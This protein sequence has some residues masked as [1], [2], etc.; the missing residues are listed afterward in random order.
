MQKLFGKKDPKEEMKEQNKV[1]R[2]A[3]RG[4]DRD[5]AQLERQKKQ[6][7]I[8]IK[9]AA[10]DG[11]KQACVI[12]AK[13]LVQLQKQETRMIAASSK[14]T[15]IKTHTTVMESNMK[16]AGAMKT[17]TD[18]INLLRLALIAFLICFVLF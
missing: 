18:V 8:Q 9:K 11:N 5:R 12:L 7:E 1:L 13:Q 17:T 4:I 10:K 15:G 6:L 14:I 3:Q 2:G 16:M